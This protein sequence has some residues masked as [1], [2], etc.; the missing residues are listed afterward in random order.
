M[1]YKA[2]GFDYGGVIYGQPGTV[3]TAAVLQALNIDRQ[4]WSE[5]YHRHYK[6]RNRDEVTWEELY[7]LILTDLGKPEKL[8][9]L[10]HIDD[11]YYGSATVNQPILDIVDR[12]RAEGYKLGLLSN[13][14]AQL[15]NE[16]KQNG[17]AVH[18]DIINISA[19]TG[20]VKPEPQAFRGFAEELGVDL[21]E[22]VFIDDSRNS[23]SM[24]QECGYTPLLFETVG[25]L[26]A[27]LA[28]M[29]LAA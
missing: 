16:I 21:S 8:D 4:T 27:D 17:V 3:Y 20:F 29:G 24:S 7:Q 6:K 25:K 13:N 1:T 2:I 19:I 26:K 15:Q 12:L 18:F 23:L 9:E 22:L 11:E 28:E 14:G 5:A 10:L